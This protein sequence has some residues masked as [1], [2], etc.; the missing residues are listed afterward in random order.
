MRFFPPSHSRYSPPPSPQDRR[1]PLTLNGRPACTLL[2]TQ[3][4]RK[5]GEVPYVQKSCPKILSHYITLRSRRPSPCV[6]PLCD[7]LL[8]S[9]MFQVFL[10]PGIIC[11]PSGCSKRQ[12]LVLLPLP[13]YISPAHVKHEGDSKKSNRKLT[14]PILHQQYPIHP[15]RKISI[16]KLPALPRTSPCLITGDDNL[17]RQR[18]HRHAPLWPNGC[19]HVCQIYLCG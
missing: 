1:T 3:T 11:R 5:M 2:F 4:K 10:V 15:S 13:Q 6:M 18:A 16:P 8:Y 7:T 14:Q 12:S 17:R 19:E 9:P